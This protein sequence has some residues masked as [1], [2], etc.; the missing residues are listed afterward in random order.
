MTG[1]LRQPESTAPQSTP[2]GPRDETPRGSSLSVK[3]DAGLSDDATLEK[4]RHFR[5]SP[6]VATPPSR[7]SSV[8]P[9]H[10]G[11]G[12]TSAL[13]ASS[14]VMSGSSYP[15]QRRQLHRESDPCTCTPP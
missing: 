9:H 11:N 4:D 15:P 10:E 6:H 2:A 14:L 5:P 3:E 12:S 13:A 7:E 8:S 1:H